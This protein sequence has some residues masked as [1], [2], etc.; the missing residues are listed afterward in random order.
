MTVMKSNMQ[1][2]ETLAEVERRFCVEWGALP[3]FF[4]IAPGRVNLIGE[5]VDYNMGWVLPAAIEKHVV[6]AANPNGGSRIRVRS[7]GFS[8]LVSVDLGEL[9]SRRESGWG[10]YVVGVL[11]VLAERGVDLK[12]FD[13]YLESTIPSGGG[14]SSSA[15]LEAA[16]C[17]AA[18]TVAGESM[19]EME[20]AKLCQEAEHRFGGVPCGLMDQAAVFASREGSLLLMDCGEETVR[21]VPF[22]CEDWAIMILNTGVK[23]NL[24][25]GEYAV[26]R[27]CCEEAANLLGLPSLRSL[28]PSQLQETL[29]REDLNGELRR[30][31]RHVVTENERVLRCVKS[32][33]SGDMA[34]VGRLLNESHE[35]LR[36]DYRVS[37]RELDFVAKTLQDMDAVTGC[38][39]T[40][41]GF[42][43]SCVAIVRS[44][45]IRSVSEYAIR[46]YRKEYGGE[47]DVF[48]SRPVGGSKVVFN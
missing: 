22:D 40:G 20:M 31:I 19:G 5:H 21:H 12:G 29:S 7:S 4:A 47:L 36:S 2:V 8:E 33:R 26:R 37:C 6:L 13:G 27:R 28:E 43:G 14:L 41:G 9:H 38:R 18:L 15:A 45:E 17:Q 3:S 25:D 44:E 23:H 39:M 11:T 24:A 35:S 10:R 32:L 16:V 42:G 1:R 46:A 48:S 30:C 34:T